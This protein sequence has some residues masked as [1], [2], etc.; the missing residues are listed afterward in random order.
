MQIAQIATLLAVVREPHALPGWTSAEAPGVLSQRRDAFLPWLAQWVALSGAASLPIERQRRL[1][2]R[3]VPLYASRG[4]R[5]SSP[6]PRT[7]F[8]MRR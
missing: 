1:I 4:T 3:I 2:G 5:D 8:A 7:S 6:R